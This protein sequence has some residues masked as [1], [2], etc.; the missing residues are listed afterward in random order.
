MGPCPFSK[1]IRGPAVAA[2]APGGPQDPD[3]PHRSCFTVRGCRQYVAVHRSDAALQ[4]SACTLESS[5]SQ[6][7]PWA[8]PDCATPLRCCHA[9]LSHSAPAASLQVRGPCG[10]P[11][12]FRMGPKDP[13][14]TPLSYASA[15]RPLPT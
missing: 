2:T 4:A 1:A 11:A 8:S 5:S 14:T 10:Q 6:C 13:G 3:R 12:T 9:H 15:R 7:L